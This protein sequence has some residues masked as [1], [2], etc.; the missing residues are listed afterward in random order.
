MHSRSAHAS[1]IKRLA[2][3]GFGFKPMKARK[4]TEHRLHST[5]LN[6]FLHLL[7]LFDICKFYIFVVFGKPVFYHNCKNNDR[8]EWEENNSKSIMC[9]LILPDGVYPWDDVAPLSFFME[10]FIQSSLLRLSSNFPLFKFG[11]SLSTSNL[12]NFVVSPQKS[13]HEITIKKNHRPRQPHDAVC[14]AER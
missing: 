7:Y 11:T 2:P 10:R 4:N 3:G 1:Q 9:C 5:F 14:G 13:G 8:P 6:I 12:S